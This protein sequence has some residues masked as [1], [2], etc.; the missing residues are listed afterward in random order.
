M[1]TWKATCT[2]LPH[3]WPVCSAAPPTTQLQ[4]GVCQGTESGAMAAKCCGWQRSST[5]TLAAAPICAGWKHTISLI[6]RMNKCK[7]PKCAFAH[8]RQTDK[9]KFLC[10]AAADPGCLP[11]S[12]R[13]DSHLPLTFCSKME[14]GSFYLSQTG[15][16]HLKMRTKKLQDFVESN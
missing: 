10:S 11:T 5:T 15:R 13:G 3:F 16:F 9:A 14:G 6:Q 7:R 1:P 2:A 8:Y 12:L 4:D